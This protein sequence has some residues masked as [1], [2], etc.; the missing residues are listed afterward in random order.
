M[1][2]LFSTA[3]PHLREVGT[4][5]WMSKGYFNLGDCSPAYGK[6]LQYPGLRNRLLDRL[7]AD[8]AAQRNESTPEELAEETAAVQC[9]KEGEHVPFELDSAMTVIR[10]DNDQVRA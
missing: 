4:E 3:R 2:R 1:R 9:V 5:I 7:S 10:H 8:P 6:G